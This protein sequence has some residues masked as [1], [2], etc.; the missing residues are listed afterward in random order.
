MSYDLWL[1][2]PKSGAVLESD[3]P[4]DLKGGTY[5]VGGTRR[6]E[7]NVTYNYS[8]HFRRVID[9]GIRTLDGKS[10]ADTIPIL[11]EAIAKL[12]DDVDLD[13][14]AATEGNAK[15]AL[16]DLLQLAEMRSDGMW[17]VY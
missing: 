15:R 11:M 7:L 8:E 17:R 9:G 6:L 2:D 16:R 10:G 12:G 1:I 4:H 3:E 5:M 14:W 13:Y